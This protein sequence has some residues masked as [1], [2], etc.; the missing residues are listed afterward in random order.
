M[1]G[2]WVRTIATM[3]ATAA[4]IS[5]SRTPKI[6]DVPRGT[7]ASAVTLNQNWSPATRQ[8]M[9]GLSFGSRLLPYAWLRHLERVDSSELFFS[10]DHIAELGFIPRPQTADNPDGLPIGFTADSGGESPWLGLTCTA[11]HTGIVRY[12]GHRILV[13]G[14]P[15]MFDFFAFETRLNNALAALLSDQKKFDRFAASLAAAP[16]TVRHTVRERHRFLQQRIDAN[17]GP[18]AYG[19]GRLDAFGQIFNAISVEALGIEANAQAA[20]APV[21]VPVLWDASHLDVVQWNASAANKEPGPLGQNVTTALAVYGTIDLHSDA[22]LGYRSSVNIKN[23]SQLQRSYYALTS[24]QWPEDLLGEIDMAQ[25]EQGQAIYRDHC[26]HCHALIDSR[27][28]ARKLRAGVVPQNIIGTDPVMAE[29]FASARATSG[30]FTG[31]KRTASIAGD[32][33]PAETRTLDLVLHA[34]TSVMANQPLTSL[35]AVLRERQPQHVFETDPDARNYKA[36]PLNG[37]WASAPYLHN[38]SVPT[39]YDLL[40][41]PPLRPA[42]FEVGTQDFDPEHLGLATAAGEYTSTF[43]T[44][45]YGNGNQ[46]HDIATHLPEQEKMAL[47]EFLKTL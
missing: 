4:V 44:R 16:D 10:N 43:D 36:R 23:L 28:P 27:N 37:L 15:G 46:G 47:I 35:L 31:R 25:A 42:Q 45:L 20:D 34:T 18:V 24:P 32:R 38:G 21:S 41:P 13:D 7:L 22:W 39:V 19:Y 40:Q 1:A 3:V 17:Y 6:I 14:G 33:L 8:Q 29:N 2:T 26:Q 9:N 11:C 5:C 12:Q 30:Q